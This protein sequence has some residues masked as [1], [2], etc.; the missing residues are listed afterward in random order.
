LIQPVAR[1]TQR[2]RGGVKQRGVR[3]A[4]FKTIIIEIK[5]NTSTINNKN[6]FVAF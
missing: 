2:Q 6:G 1:G 4:Q 3:W 5:E